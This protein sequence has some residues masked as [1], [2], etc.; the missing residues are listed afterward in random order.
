LVNSQDAQRLASEQGN[1]I[2]SRKAE[3]F[4]MMREIFRAKGLA[5]TAKA[6]FEGFK[7]AAADKKVRFASEETA[8][9]TED[10]V[11]KL[12]QVLTRQAL[13]TSS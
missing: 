4:E 12:L 11:Q 2:A 8:V 9:A 6:L 3:R 5:H 7:Q 13:L 1:N 10:Q